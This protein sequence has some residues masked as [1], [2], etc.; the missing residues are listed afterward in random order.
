MRIENSIKN[1][2][3]S[4][5]CIAIQII[6]GFVAQK[7]FVSIL[8]IEY[9]GVGGLFTN[10]LTVL[11][12]AE[13]GIGTAITYKLY[14]P[15]A[16]KDKEKI[17]SLVYLYRKSYNTI[18]IVVFTL[19]LLV[20]PFLNIFI[21]ETTLDLNFKFVYILFLLQTVS[22][23]ILADK[24]A[25]LCAS[26]KNYITNITH[27][28]YFIVVN[29]LQLSLLY[30]TKN[31]YL[32]LTIKMICVLLENLA[33]CIITEKKYPFIKEKKIKYLDKNVQDD[34]TKR[35]KAMFVHKVSGVVNEG[36]D[37][38]LISKYVGLYEVGLYANYCLILNAVK[39]LLGNIIS[40]VTAS[41]GNLLVEGNNKKSF[42]IYQKLNFLNFWIATFA[43]TATLVIIQSFITIWLG[44]E[45]LF[46]NYVLIIM[47]TS[48]YLGMVKGTNDTFVNAAGLF[49]ETRG[50]A[51]VQ[52]T[53]KIIFSIILTKYIGIIGIFVGTIIASIPIWT[54]KYPKFVYKNLLGGN[55]K[56]YIKDNLRYLITFAG[57]AGATYFLA[58]SIKIDNAFVDFLKNVVFGF[59]MPNLI[60][61]AIYLK[62]EKFKYYIDLAKE[63]IDK[64]FKK[65]H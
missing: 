6:I 53:L 26:Q 21:G 65:C 46:P 20:L 58:Q 12:I 2:A 36:I 44:N 45:F 41:V 3:F 5:F 16:E 30:F 23:Y 63:F 15:I 13:L 35:V 22:T 62:D 56:D 9:S 32:Y 60:L 47:I 1:S 4:I 43:C 39:M 8:G 50:V 25:L 52:M 10:I 54:Y 38:I 40:S 31:Y 48:M 19:G 7:I 29:S 11:G 59:V 57:V 64:K 18:A 42:S 17:K 34:I 24:K 61:L 14:K 28:C 37:N 51:I 49:V 33:L 55:Y 27:I